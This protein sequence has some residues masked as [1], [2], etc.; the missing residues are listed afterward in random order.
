M[1]QP[2]TAALRRAGGPCQR[3]RR[4]SRAWRAGG[5][6]RRKS[7]TARLRDGSRAGAGG[8]LR[9]AGGDEGE[10]GEERAAIGRSLSVPC[11]IW[12]RF[13]AYQRRP[14]ASQ[15]QPQLL[16][17]GLGEPLHEV[18]PAQRDIA[19]VAADLGLRALLR[20]RG[21]PRRRA[22]S[23][24]PCAR[25]RRPP[26]TRPA[27]RQARA[28]RR[29]LRTDCPGNRCAG[30]KRAP[31]CRDRRRPRRAAATWARVRNCASSTRTQCELRAA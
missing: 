9:L 27:R 18:A 11:Q 7:R 31:E 25:I 3:S 20:P 1:I 6:D 2:C 10:G 14:H 30:H 5:S 12:D 17:V 29:C 15:R 4:C 13:A 22:G 26:S 8:T 21:R 28:G 24:S 16:A 19:V 23:S